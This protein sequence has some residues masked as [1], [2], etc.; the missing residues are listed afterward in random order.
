M[1]V[2]Q[3]VKKYISQKTGVKHNT[4]AG[5]KTV[6]NILTKETFG[7]YRIDKVKQSDAKLF[8]IKLQKE[9]GKSYSSIQ[10]IRGALPSDFS[11]GS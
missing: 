6:I 5:Y 9:N 8:F 2:L 7:C 3:L 1:T 4:E 11:D 10:S